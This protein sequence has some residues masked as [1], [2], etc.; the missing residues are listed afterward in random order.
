[1]DRQILKVEG[2]FYVPMKDGETKE[3]ATD[4]FNDLVC[5]DDVEF[6]IYKVSII[7]DDGNEICEATKLPCSKCMP[8]CSMKGRKHDRV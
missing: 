1:M 6:A 3:Q 2:S 5:I 7:N 4:R 8:C